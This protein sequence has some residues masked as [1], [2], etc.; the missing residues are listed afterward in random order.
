[1][2]NSLAILDHNVMK[3]IFVSKLSKSRYLKNL[4]L[5]LFILFSIVYCEK[6]YSQNCLD[7]INKNILYSGSDE[8]INGQKWM[9]E[10][11]FLGSPLLI[12]NYWPKADISYNGSKYSGIILNWDVLKNE[13]I[14]FHSDKGKDKYVVL[15][16]NDLSGFS[17][18]DTVWNRKHIYEYVNLAGTNGKALYENA[19]TGIISFYIKPVKTVEANSA[20]GLG[21]YTNSYEYFI[22]TGNGYNSF[23][24]KKQL[25]KL[26]DNHS[27][28]IS[29]F[30]RK[31]K[32]KIN[33]QLPDHVIAVLRYYDGLK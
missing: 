1:M 18:T 19:S 20:N 6:G 28:E 5:R 4:F 29:R 16:I 11:K 7:E 17:F 26:L 31:N 27:S 8:I 23:R 15:G 25:I 21:V 32:L 33:S 12:E 22:D 24:T 9:Y 30:I 2:L 3:Y 13:L 14:V 10:K